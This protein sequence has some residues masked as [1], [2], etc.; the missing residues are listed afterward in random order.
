M[1]ALPALYI[2]RVDTT[3]LKGFNRAAYLLCPEPVQLHKTSPNLSQ[4]K[5]HLAKE[6]KVLWKRLG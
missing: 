1:N 4:H 3:H 2:T 5:V 6:I